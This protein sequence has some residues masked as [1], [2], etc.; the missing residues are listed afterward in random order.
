MNGQR[1]AIKLGI[2]ALAMFGFGFALVPL[3]GWVCDVAGLQR[4]GVVQTAIGAPGTISDRTVTVRFDATVQANL[5]WA[6]EPVQPMR[7]VRLGET[8]EVSYR[9]RNLTSKAITAQ[10]VPSVTPWQATEHF[11]KIACFCFD[12]QTLQGGEEREM[13]LRFVVDPNLPEGIDSLTISYA[14]MGLPQ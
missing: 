1:M 5:P 10:A 13:P 14:F 11:S 4:A 12:R 8:T 2:T 6:F 9:A 3:Y 7:R